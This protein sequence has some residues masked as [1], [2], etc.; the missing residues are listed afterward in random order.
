MLRPIEYAFS[1]AE[2]GQCRSI[3]ELRLELKLRGLSVE[4]ITG[5]S[6]LRQLSAAIAK[7]SS[8]LT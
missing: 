7:S 3:S 1:L 8:K 5:R 2:S 6:L 4:Q